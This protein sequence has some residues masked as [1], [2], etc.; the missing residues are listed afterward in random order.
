M[1]LPRIIPPR[2]YRSYLDAV[3][4][5]DSN[6][7]IDDVLD[8]AAL[9]YSADVVI[10]DLLAPVQR[11]IGERW[12]DARM[13]VAQEHRATTISE[14]ALAALLQRHVL[15]DRQAQGEVLLCAAEGEWHSIAARMVALVW[16]HLGWDVTLLVPSAPADSLL[17]VIGNREAELVGVSCILPGN[18]YG[19]WRVIGV[20]RQ[21][22]C[23]IVAGGRAFGHG[24]VA[25]HRASALGADSYAA[26]A[27]A[28]STVLKELAAEPSPGSRP[29]E[30]RGAAGAEADALHRQSGEL[31]GSSLRLLE[32]LRPD[33]LSDGRMRADLGADV[34][35]LVEALTSAVLLEDSTILTEHLAWYR[36]L[37]SNAGVEELGIL[38]ADGISR[39]LSPKDYPIAH[40]LL[41]EAIRRIE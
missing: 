21:R 31:A 40:Q 9:G 3:A 37:A 18:L 22:G 14:S 36:S 6:Q 16:R 35:L 33:V 28:G 39:C 8:L 26:E 5:G 11:E 19:A 25:A 1:Y 32:G 15:T 34:E 27:L 41:S 12:A 30:S 20:L 2:Y 7:A 4:R 24:A 17:D 29:P 38:L 10:V 23:R 13:G